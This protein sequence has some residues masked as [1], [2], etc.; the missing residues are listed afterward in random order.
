[1]R[2]RALLALA[3]ISTTVAC[4]SPEPGSSDDIAVAAPIAV[5]D[6][7]AELEVVTRP[8]EPIAEAYATIDALCTDYVVRANHYLHD[9]RLDAPP[10]ENFQPG[11]PWC[12]SEGPFV[13]FAA[14]G[15]YRSLRVVGAYDGIRTESRLVLETPRG[16]ELTPISWAEEDPTDP[17]CGSIVRPEFIDAAYVEHGH[18]VVMLGGTRSAYVEPTEDGDDGYRAGLVKVASWCKEDGAA[19]NCFELGGGFGMYLAAKTAPK[20][21]WRP[22]WA[23]LAWTNEITFAID[24]AGRVELQER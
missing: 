10:E 11:E 21:D 8:L 16:L 2:T 23:S 3:A 13:A 9:G 5:S 14:D 1:V 20:A 6:E 12:R 4:G 17:G 22:D 19:L 15:A 24:E 18:L 7:R